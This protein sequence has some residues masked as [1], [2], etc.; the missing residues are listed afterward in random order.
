MAIQIPEKGA[1]RHLTPSNTYAMSQHLGNETWSVESLLGPCQI[2]TEQA[3]KLTAAC[4]NL[5]AMLSEDQSAPRKV[6]QAPEPEEPNHYIIEEFDLKQRRPHQLVV[7]QGPKGCGK[8]TLLEAIIKNGTTYA[9]AT[10]FVDDMC[11]SKASGAP[12]SPTLK[13]AFQ[14]VVPNSNIVE[15]FGAAALKDFASEVTKNLESKPLARHLVVV[16]AT[17]FLPLSFRDA[18]LSLARRSAAYRVDLIVMTHDIDNVGDL[19]KDADYLFLGGKR[20]SKLPKSVL[21]PRFDSPADASAI[22]D[23]CTQDYGFLAIDR[24]ARDTVLRRAKA[25]LSH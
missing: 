12:M 9:M 20:D 15:S 6:Q 17:A 14:G 10:A 21:R 2:I 25:P 11:L 3:S 5:A 18:L 13:K 19:V 7:I 24:S 16:E 4:A 22:C 23:L 8:S 1:R